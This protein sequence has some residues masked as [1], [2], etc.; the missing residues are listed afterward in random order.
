MQTALIAG[1]TGLVG[2]EL[3]NQLISNTQFEKVIVLSRRELAVSHP[4]LEVK[5]IDF[6]LLPVIKF[7]NKIDVCFC[8]LGT[9][10][11]KAGVEG[12]H[13]VDFQY[14][15]ALAQLCKQ[16]N[17][18]TFLVISAQGADSKSGISY[19]RS[20]GQ[21]EDAVNAMELDSTYIIRPALIS[22]ERDE[23]RFGEKIGFVLNTLMIPILIGKLRKFRPV[24]GT[25]IARCMVEL[26]LKS[27]KGTFV[28][29]SDKILKY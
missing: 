9:T 4:K 20:K 24:S 6:D 29:E 27:Q 23:Y 28:I 25:K 19:S 14:V 8:C 17:V 5:L 7:E 26:A 10:Q 21:M 22:G 15:V 12:R 11:K 2:K 18:P 16:L 1:A 3:I 13:K